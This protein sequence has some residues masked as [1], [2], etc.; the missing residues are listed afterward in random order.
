MLASGSYLVVAGGLR[1]PLRIERARR[2][3]LCVRIPGPGEIPDGMVLIPGGP[4]LAPTGAGGRLERGWLPDFA[5]GR[6]PVTMGEYAAFLDSLSEKERARRMP[7]VTDE[8]PLLVRRDGR[9]TLADTCVEGDARAYVPSERA[10][11][12]PLH[13]VTWYDACAYSEWRARASGRRYRMP[14]ALEW[15]KAMRGADGRSFSMGNHFDPCFAKTLR[16]RPVDSQPEPVG[17]FPLDESPHGVRDL[18]GGVADWTSTMLAGGPLP[19]IHDEA[20]AELDERLALFMG[21]H[22]GRLTTVSGAQYAFRLVNRN[23]GVGLRLA[24]GLDEETSDLHVEPMAR[25]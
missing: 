10:L 13:G 20:D 19:S 8:L 25:P 21:G 18:V 11:E 1:Y 16:S 17:A 14:S 12:V 23:S 22:W 9:W 24:L 3:R 7:R 15:E 5:I 2:H 6:F 4:F